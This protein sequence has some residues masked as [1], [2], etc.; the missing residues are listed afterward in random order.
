MKK[1]KKDNSGFTLVELLIAMV[2]IAVVLTPLYNNFRQSTYLN[3]KAKA[4]MDA[5]NMASNIMEGLSAYSAEEI[6]LGFYTLDSVS[7]NNPYRHS[8]LNIMPNEVTVADYG[9][10]SYAGGSFNKN[11]SAG[12]LTPSTASDYAGALYAKT[13]TGGTAPQPLARYLQ[14][15]SSGSYNGKYYFYAEGVTQARGTYDIMVCLDTSYDTGFSGD[16]DG[17]GVINGAETIGYND[18]ESALITNINPLFDGVYTETA[19]QRSNVAADFLTKRSNPWYSPITQPEDFYPYLQRTVTIDVNKIPGASGNQATVTVT[20]TYK[21]TYYDW[22][23]YFSGSNEYSLAPTTVFDGD[24]YGT[25]PREIYIYYNGNYNSTSSA[26]G[27]CLDNFVINNPD[28]IPVNIHLMRLKTAETDVNKEE[29][30]RAR[31]EVN[32]NKGS[33]YVTDIYS[34]LRDNLEKNSAENQANRANFNRVKVKI[35][36]YEISSASDTHIADYN[37]VVHETG[38]VRTEKRERLFAVT[39]YVYEEGA[40]DAGFPE[41]MLITEF[42]GNSA[43]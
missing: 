38:G 26:A 29:N 7:N 12:G 5:T 6:I 39:M 42:D 24:V 23:S 43:Q 19:G 20:E 16:A 30:Y 8:T 37:E 9:D 13:S 31:I 35:D 28:K 14:V 10:L 17:N 34:N 22:G 33:G 25:A 36:I 27:S 1:I 32:E 40:A 4:T 18:Y 21:V 15:D 2:I 11:F 3:G 41:D